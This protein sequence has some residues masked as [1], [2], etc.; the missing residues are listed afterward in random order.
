M[1]AGTAAVDIEIGIYY[2]N[3]GDNKAALPYFQHA[4]VLGQGA[5][6][7]QISARA[8]LLGGKYIQLAKGLRQRCHISPAGIC[9]IPRDQ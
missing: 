1:R 3:A 7:S 6:D 9:R 4:E 5:N 8:A 2:Q